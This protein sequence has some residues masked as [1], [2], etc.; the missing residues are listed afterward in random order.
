LQDTGFHTSIF[1]VTDS[2][3]CAPRERVGQ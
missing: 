2:P 1:T 3:A